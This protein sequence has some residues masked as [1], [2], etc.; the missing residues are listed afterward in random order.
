MK[1]Q[2]CAGQ[3]L[4]ARGSI[5]TRLRVDSAFYPSEAAFLP[6]HPIPDPAF[7]PPTQAPTITNDEKKSTKFYIGLVIDQ[8][9][10][11]RLLLLGNHGMQL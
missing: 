6:A 3:L 9:N 5:L 11:D 2:Y 10:K 8:V 1:M 4:T 7:L